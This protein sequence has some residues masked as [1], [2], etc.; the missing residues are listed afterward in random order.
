MEVVEFLIDEIARTNGRLDLRHMVKG[1]ADRRQHKEGCTQ[2]SWQNL[3]RSNLLQPIVLTNPISRATRVK[4][5]VELVRSLMLTCGDKKKAMAE[6][7]LS[8]SVFYERLKAVP[9][10]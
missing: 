2:T 9:A 7:G 6:S 3:I 10:S 5:E 1:W 8:K 4:T